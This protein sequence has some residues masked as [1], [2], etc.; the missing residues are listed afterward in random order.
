MKERR[1]GGEDQLA[2]NVGRMKNLIQ[3]ERYLFEII[4][5]FFVLIFRGGGGE[6]QREGERERVGR[7]EGGREGH[8]R[9]IGLSSS[10]F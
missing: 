1:K 6:R 5:N 4:F 3:F 10:F 9:L 7:E 8:T 2:E